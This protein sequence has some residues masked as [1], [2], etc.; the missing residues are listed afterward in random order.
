MRNPWKLTSFALIAML[1]VVIGRDAVGG[2]SAEPQPRM[3]EALGHLQAAQASLQAATP[4]KGGHR[5]KAIA[6]TKKAIQQV[7]AGIKFDNRH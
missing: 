5:V 6:L 7:E 1:A 4:D 3:Q 2:A